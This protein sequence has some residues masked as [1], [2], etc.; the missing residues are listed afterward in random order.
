[1]GNAHKPTS[2]TRH[3]NIKYFSLCD[4]VERDIMFLERIDTSLNMSDN[5]TK[6]LETI[7]FH[8]HTDF[9]LGH[10]V[11]MCSLVYDT[12]VGRFSNHTLDIDH[13]VPPIFYYSPNCRCG[14]SSCSHRLWLQTQPLACYHWAW[15]LQ[16]TL[17]F[18]FTFSL[19]TLYVRQWIVGR[20][21]RIG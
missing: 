6:G 2:R 18:I 8:C 1:M 13:L 12:I 14:L 5:M 3:I 17:F 10:I 7:L 4:W 11:P 9:I 20:W 19:F 21:Y 16:S 15:T